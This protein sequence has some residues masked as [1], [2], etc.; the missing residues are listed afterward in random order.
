MR[1]VGLRL[2]IVFVVG[3]FTSCHRTTPSAGEV[4][5]ADLRAIIENQIK[6]NIRE[7]Y[8]EYAGQNF[9]DDDLDSFIGENVPGKVVDTLRNNK[10]FLAAVAKVRVL[11]PDDR[12]TYLL[13]CRRPLH[14]TWAEMGEI[15]PRGQTVAG[16]KAEGILAGAV[17]DLAQSLLNGSGAP[18]AR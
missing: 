12:V 7:S 3:M 13:G 11:A 15:S 6:D 9:S 14:K 16:L 4:R 18:P 1:L 5:G 8:G 17:V 2:A 10:V